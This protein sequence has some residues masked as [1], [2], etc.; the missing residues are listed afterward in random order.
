M[1]ERE[2]ERERRGGG[3]GGGRQENR[4]IDGGGIGDMYC[5]ERM[6]DEVGQSIAC[7][8][9]AVVINR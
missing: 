6:E 7:V 9:W 8:L 3:R 5:V 4:K 2:R 1:Q